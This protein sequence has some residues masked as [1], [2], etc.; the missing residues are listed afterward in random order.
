MQQPVSTKQ[1][2]TR[3]PK[4]S[5]RFYGKRLQEAREAAD[6]TQEDMVGI[7]LSLSSIQ[8]AERSIT[9]SYETAMAICCLLRIRPEDYLMPENCPVIP[10]PAAVDTINELTKAEEIKIYRR[11][12]MY[13]GRRYS[14]RVIQI[15]QAMHDDFIMENDDGL[16]AAAGTIAGDTIRFQV[17][18]GEQPASAI[19]G[20][21]Y[22]I[23]R[24][25]A[26]GALA[27][28]I[29][30][31]CSLR[32]GFGDAGGL[33]GKY[34]IIECRG[35]YKELTCGFVDYIGQREWALLWRLVDILD[36]P[37]QPRTVHNS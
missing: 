5:A 7:G 19:D 6:L 11:P 21:V 8:R 3:G 31:E 27:D 13:F 2:K 25:H 26:D 29:H 9:V 15:G 1:K 16:A 33:K 14:I 34:F 4:R 28:K 35:K 24:I 17:A 22:R 10:I 20:S 12:K 30:T 23:H 32:R 36:R 37:P 18:D